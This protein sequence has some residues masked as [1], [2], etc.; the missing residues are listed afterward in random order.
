MK[1]SRRTKRKQKRP[2]YAVIVDGETEVWYLNMLKRNERQI[3]V[4]IKPEI[5][6]KKSLKEQYKSVLNLAE[7]GNYKKVF[8]LVDY[9]TIIKETRE[10]AKA[11]RS[12]EEVFN[13][14]TN[15]LN[16]DFENVVVIVNN[17]CL[18]FW[19]LLHFENTSRFFNDCT[20]VSRRLST[21]LSDYE[22]TR[23]YFTKQNDD[24]YLKLQPY[25]S[26]AY[27]NAKLLGAYSSNSNK[28]RA[29]C[30]MG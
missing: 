19:F 11:S 26:S 8:W 12:P 13:Q 28:R 14:Y 20:S 29:I 21:H 7:S 2:N 6:N 10:T 4:N 22:K 30:E 18:E 24:I 9:D 15:S 23:R 16:K 25:L 3:R 1:R 27:N 5:P 17:P